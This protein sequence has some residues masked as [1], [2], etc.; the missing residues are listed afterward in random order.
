MWDLLVK[1]NEHGAK[2]ICVVIAAIIGLIAAII[3]RWRVVEH[4]HKTQESV[5][6]SK[7]QPVHQPVPAVDS[8]RT[9][10]TM[11]PPKVETQPA[12][13]VEDHLDTQRQLRTALTILS[14][15]LIGLIISAA[16]M[17]LLERELKPHGMVVFGQWTDRKGQVLLIAW[18]AG[19]ASTCLW[20]IAGL[21]QFVRSIYLT[22]RPAPPGV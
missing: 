4:I 11:L 5:R 19:L 12:I 17:L 18:Y 13:D 20:G 9:P 2:E 3:S 22:T 8:S 7:S 10:D 15:C 21:Y 16:L 14:V 6:L 1:L